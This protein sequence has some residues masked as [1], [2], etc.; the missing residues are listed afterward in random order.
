MSEVVALLLDDAMPPERLGA[1]LLGARKRSGLKRKQAAA[2]AGTTAGRL[3]KYE[4][5][6]L[7]VPAAICAQLAECYGDD[8][9][10]HVPLR[11]P[12]QIETHRV[13][14][15]DAEQPVGPGIDDVLAGYI[16][17]VRRLRST[18]PGDPLALRT[19]DIVALAGALGRDRDAIER[20]IAEVLGC[21]PVEAR[22]LHSELLRRKVILPVAG[23]AAG[24]AAF[25]GV[26]YAAQSSPATVTH[27]QTT[28][29]VA[30]AAPTT[31]TTAAPTPTTEAPTPTTAAPTPPSTTPPTT[32]PVAHHPAPTPAVEQQ[33]DATVPPAQRTA[34]VPDTIAGPQPDPNDPPV[35]VLPGE[36]PITIIGAPDSTSQT[37]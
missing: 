16:D 26:A 24:M 14:V 37:P 31:S 8:L 10:A 25:A 12:M 18:G 13:A 6:D 1:L 2:A 35:S 9:T 20:Q 29:I 32:V 34:D 19:V 33:V 28:P 15:G 3:R 22:R 36:T 23:L 5:G 17:I 11:V 21:S 27:I 7:P 30:S 4:Q